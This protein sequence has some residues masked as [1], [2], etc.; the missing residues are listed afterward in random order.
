MAWNNWG[1]RPKDQDQIILAT[2]DWCDG[3]LFDV[4]TYNQETDSLLIN[5]AES[6]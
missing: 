5:D 3:W 4:A 1:N 2:W 6:E